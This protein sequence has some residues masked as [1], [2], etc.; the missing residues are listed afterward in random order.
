ML[1]IKELLREPES[2][3]RVLSELRAFSNSYVTDRSLLEHRPTISL[4][5]LIRQT[6]DLD[7]PVTEFKAVDG[8]AP[9]K[10]TFITEDEIDQ[11]LADGPSLQ[12]S[13]IR[14]YSYFI[15]GH[16]AKE[17]AALLRHEYGDSGHVSEGW[18][19]WSDG[20]GIKLTRSD[21][22]GDY[23]T[24]HLNWNQAQKRIRDLI[25]KDRYLTNKERE[26]LPEHDKNHLAQMLYHFFSHVPDCQHRPFSNGADAAEAAKQIIPLLETSETASK[27][28]DT[29]LSDFTTVSPDTEGYT[30]MMFAMRDMGAFVRG[31]SPLFSPL[32]E[33][34]LQAEREVKERNRK[35]GQT[36]QK[37][38]VTDAPGEASGELAAV[39][40]ALASKR[41]PEAEAQGDGQFSL[42][43]SGQAAEAETQEQR[44][45]TDA[46][47]DHFLIEDLGDPE[48][49]QRLYALFTEGWSDAII[50]RKLEQEYSRS[51]RG[52]LEGGFCT[53]ADGTR[54]YAYFTKELRISPRPEGKMRH[55]S[56][57]EMAAHIRQ[58]IQ[59]G[60]YLS[61][62][63]LEQY[64]KDHAAPEPEAPKAEV[65]KKYSL[66]YGY[67]GNGLTVWNS[68][69]MEDGDYKTI[70]HI[71]PDRRVTFYADDLPEEIKQEI[72][73]TAATSDARISATQDAPVF[74]APPQVPE[75]EQETSRSPWWDE[76]TAIKES[77]PNHL[78]LYQVGDFFELF[79]EDAKNAAA[80]LELTLTTRPIGSVGRVE[81]CGLPA[82]ALEQ[83]VEKLRGQYDVAISTVDEKTGAYQTR[84]MAALM[85]GAEPEKQAVEQSESP[86]PAGEAAAV[87]QN[88]NYEITVTSAEALILARPMSQAGI[89]PER[90]VQ[91]NGD[92]TFSVAE[93]EKDT[94][95]RLITK[96]RNDISKAAAAVSRPKKARRTR[97]ELNYSTFA[98]LFPE[99]ISGEYRSMRLQAGPSYMPLHV[100]W[101]ADDVV[102]L[103][104][105]FR[106]NGDTM[107]DPEMTFRV[108]QE[109][110]TMEALTFQQDGGV[111]IYQQVYPEPGKW[112]PKLRND[113]NNFA[114]KWMKN[115][116]AQ[117]F[118]R[119]RAV[120]VK[121]GEDVEVFFS[122]EGTPIAAYDILMREAD[123]ITAQLLND[124]RYANARMNSDEQNSRDECYI[125]INRIAV[126]MLKTNPQFYQA[127]FDTLVA[128]HQFREYLFETTYQQNLAAEQPPVSAVTL[129]REALA[130]LVGAVKGSSFYDY[131]RD[132]ETDYDSARNELDAEI[133]A[134]MEEIKE[135]NP[136]L[137]E[138]CHTLPKFREWLI[139][140]ILEQTYQ[141]VITDPRDAVQRYAGTPDAPAWI[142]EAPAQPE[143]NARETAPQE[144]MSEARDPLAPAYREGDTVYIEN[145][146]FIISKIDSFEI[147]LQYPNTVPPLLTSEEITHFE[148]LL[149]QDPRNLAISD[150][151]SADTSRITREILTAYLLTPNELEMVSHWFRSGEGNIQI[152][153][154]I[155]EML[156]GRSGSVSAPWNSVANYS[157]DDKGFRVTH[158]QNVGFRTWEEVAAIYRS[159]WQLEFDGFSHEPPTVDTLETEQAEAGTEIPQALEAAPEPTGA[160]APENAKIVWHTPAGKE[161][162]AGDTVEYFVDGTPH[163]ITIDSIGEDYI[164]YTFPD[165]AQA[166]VEMFRD[167]FE[168]LLDDGTHS[169]VQKA[170]EHPQQAP[171]MEQSEAERGD[172]TVPVEPD[173][174]PNA[175][176]Y[177]ELKAQHPDKLIGVQVGEFMM[178][179]GKDA[180]EAASALGTKA[181]ILDIPGLGQTPTT[182]KRG[183]WQATLKKLLEHGKSVV[184]ARPDL[185]RGPDA[186]YE[187]I[188]ERDISEYIPL[189]KELTIDGRRMKVD[190]IDYANGKVS[191]LDMEM[192]E[193]YRYP[194]F[195]EEPVAYVREYVEEA[196][197]RE[198]E[199]TARIENV[200][201]GQSADEPESQDHAET[202]TLEEAK[203]LIEDF[204]DAEYGRGCADFSDLEHIGIAYTTTE[205]E[206][207]EIQ[208]EVNLLDFSVTQTLDGQLIEQRRYKT[209]REMIDNELSDLDF[210]D[211]IHMSGEPEQ[212]LATVLKAAHKPGPAP[213]PE[214]VEID[215]GRIAEPP[216]PKTPMTSQVVGRV[217]AGAF[218]V[219]FEELHVGPELHNFHITDEGLG[220]G[221]QKTKYQNNVAAIRTLKQIE[222]EGRLAARSEQEILSHYV[223]WGSLAPAFD[224][225]NKAWAKEFAEL[226]SL[227]TPEEY[228]A[229]R[230]TTLS[231]HYTSPRVIKAIYDAVGR[232]GFQP[233]NILEPSC[234]IGNF[235]GLLP[236]ALSG[237]NLY[238]VELDSLTGRIARQLYQKAHIT[239]DG[240]EN[241]DHPDDFFDLAVG[242]VPF[243]SYKVHDRRYDRHNLQIHDYFL[244]KTLDKLRPG[245]I[246]AV[247]TSKGTMDKKNSKVRE[248]L[249]QKADLLGAIRLPNNAFKANAGT[250]VT[251]DILFFQKRATVPEKLPEWVESGLTADGV[252]LNQYY[253]QHPEMVL[254]TMVRGMSMYGNDTE[255]ACY[256]IEGA[257]L[258]EQLAG[259]ISH[260]APPDQELL[261]MDAPEQE[262]GKAVESIPADPNVRNFSYTV[263]KGKIYFRENSRMAPV[264]LGKKPTERVKGM[265]G[266]RDSARKL[267]DLQLKGADDTE[268]KAEQANLNRLYD[269]Y[270]KKYGILNNPGNRLAFNQDSSYPLLCSL[271]VLDDEGNFKQKADMFTKRTIQHHEAVT[272]VD[273][274]AEALA[275]S[276]GERACVDLGFM[277]SLMGDR[278]PAGSG[279]KIPQIVEDLK[280]IIFKDP[281]TGPFD[282][283]GDAVSWYKGWQTADEYLSGDVRAKLAKARA[284]AEEYPE[285]AVNAEA[286]EQVQP[287]DLTAAEISVRIGAPW[288]KPEYYR[289]F[290]FELLQVPEYLHEK[291]DVFYN[292]VTGEWNVKGKSV[293]KRD[294]ARIHATYGTKRRSAY[295]IFENLLN[296][297]DSRVYDE[298]AEGKR[299]L[300]PKHT[301]IAQQKAE[302]IDQA[303]RDWIFKDPERRADLCAT[304]N[305]IFNSKRPREYNGDHITFAGMNPE[306]KLEPHQRNAVARMLYGGNSLLAHCVGAG[307]TFEMTAA[308]M[309]S[310]RLGL[311][312]KSLFVVPNHLTEQWGSDF[313]TLY[314]GAKVLV[315]TKKDFKP[316][317]RKKFC[318]RIATG[319]YDAVIIGHSQFE[320]IPLSPERQARVIE[321]QIS[322]IMDAIREAKEQNEENWSIKQMEGTRKD[323][324]AKLKKLTDKKKDD[325]VTFEEL[326]ID[327]LFVD[328]AHYYKNLFLHTKM[329]NVAGIA[330]TEAQKSSDM[331][332][333]CRYLDELTGGRGVTFATGTPVSN[334]MVE[335]Y[336]MMRYLQFD[337]LEEAGLSHFDDWAAMFGEKVSAVELKPEG[338]GFRSKTRFARFYNLPELMNLWKEAA[339]IQTAEML[340]LPVPE[341]EYITVTTEP[342]AAQKEMVQSLAERAEAVRKGDVKPNVD[343]MLKITS[344]GRKLALDQRIMNPLLGDDPNSKVNAC[345]KNVF[346][347]WQE[348]TPTR[349]A[350]L[351]FCDLSTPK[352]RSESKK[353]RKSKI[354]EIID[355]VMGQNPDEVEEDAEG[356][357]LEMG[358]YDDIRAKLIAKGVPVEEIAFIHDAHT[359]AQKAELF[360]KVRSGQVRVLLGSTQKM[361][362]GTNVQKRLVASH[363]LDCPWRPADLEQRAGRIVRRGNDNKKVRIFRYVTKGT[364]DAYNWGLVENKQK[365][366][367]QIMTGKSPARSIEDVDATALSYAEVKM[368]AT[369]DPRIKEK[370]ELDIEVAKL[371]MLKANHM[372]QKYEMEDMVIKHYPQKMAEAKMFIRALT[373]DMQIRD[374]HPVKDDAFSMT[375][376][377]KTYT[378]R[379]A[380][381][382]AIL[383]A[384]KSMTEPDKPLDL[385]QFRGFPMQVQ[386]K[387]EKFVVTM[388]QNLT[389]TAELA[390]EILG[391]VTRI[392][393]ALEKITES[394][395]KQQRGLVT[396]EGNLENAREEA[397]RPFPQE[398]EL[399]AKSARL[400]E[401]NAELDNAESG[402]DKEQGDGKEPPQ[403]PSAPPLP[404]GD[405]P[406]I[407][408]ALRSYTP[409]APVAAGTEK[410]HYR[411][412]VL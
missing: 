190:S 387:G 173:F 341:A 297:R 28:F 281:A 46:D 144:E 243:G 278:S 142:Q 135:Q 60:R 362:A 377:G 90:T 405:K 313:L 291:I 114:A 376:C 284:A 50:V 1:R 131:L 99:I 18:Q 52:N 7:K 97:P 332:G 224:E 335:L 183:A 256:P 10:A 216:A 384:C 312:Q 363:D 251:S 239:V 198:F 19:T 39:A 317:N 98:K 324:E 146:P 345:V 159:L 307:K 179:Y 203:R 151:L 85:T 155:K 412:D 41:K 141:D 92:V 15:Q 6:A 103:G 158:Q 16:D 319:D 32:P 302:A 323:L 25:E 136:A 342:S 86:A 309:E 31:D 285:F 168:K 267:I 233:G 8:F 193:K 199:Q 229:A 29:M 253:L 257:D 214:Q 178:F 373:E 340:K 268:I 108:D 116:T 217:N 344:D 57:E 156:S 45:I 36:A 294:N 67:L 329:R 305:R 95:E 406:S 59:E 212:L 232:M 386:L 17:C 287:K 91:E 353:P 240:F 357:K 66:G 11:F 169:I 147:Q 361:G 352:G 40:R 411:G 279:D 396:L 127:Y 263:S 125:A 283:D 120:A 269:A 71:A 83:N 325:T 241:T 75:Q 225:H 369:G 301:A 211:L 408:A 163:Q 149:R 322:E 154:R 304:Y 84:T 148:Y 121:D 227:L 200:M 238:G 153:G 113:L 300:N 140:D 186:P 354:R 69:E 3:R 289:Q 123:A 112:I 128:V 367:G 111:P 210:E 14:I 70:A 374:M 275:V 308:A 378:E 220:T 349:G 298:G 402:K 292:K 21:E 166:P 371:K 55:V 259:A 33:S 274:A 400:S 124:E 299:V 356:V 404:G 221:G 242:N 187:I 164:Y 399:A 176:K 110:G 382:E 165:L 22:N 236:E 321:D 218:D 197:W 133:T 276:I 245:G 150:F 88:P 102:A 260:I 270:T 37:A 43:S 93:A 228:A 27:L 195:R 185:Q 35:K 101:I 266:I 47:L 351:V 202:D 295:V 196:E 314:P 315:A 162:R 87:V 137:H 223:G 366:I 355:K 51:R 143:R 180:E 358:V 48:R 246:M 104:H 61:P 252:P 167:R 280:G 391:N 306:Y 328:E 360:A 273:T 290:L 115:I 74:S 359:E 12:D 172:D 346:E 53:L 330:Q 194:V 192:A 170:S 68:M 105:T 72:Q 139:E 336:T 13:K 63:E 350:Q 201:E 390:D 160:G 26:S 272:S 23:D 392:N 277:A 213:E 381:G 403:E 303:F 206:R 20:K 288:V 24:V 80:V 333:K 235:F 109:K 207:H 337:M 334:S 343:N 134:M 316:K 370:M 188:K 126:S 375:I 383:A 132:R 76:Y 209:L 205:D 30:G 364:F 73:H 161:Y 81:M 65:E 56:F 106:Q 250:E 255:T 388:K 62:E 389:Y 318:A 231:A 409:P 247:I 4:P 230:A 264:E 368:L 204:C 94:L 262:D 226:Q 100:Q 254:G 82:H 58:L 258:A 38:A 327:R 372:A 331:F 49:R 237:A 379:K 129:Y 265:I 338:T 234:G 347:I 181:P 175:E 96:I 174:T 89:T 394:L 77:H 208:V 79:G 145:K 177:W 261:E 107:N 171:A 119:E 138:A 365:F 385:G 117:K 64:Q 2:R 54:G 326:G 191:L 152:A 398:E 397:A 5:A 122:P 42:F 339:D 189:G 401:L 44:E 296:Q 182:G 286:L 118:I 222:A 293:D 9:A 311:C 271:E 184:L 157:T 248:A 34:A 310:K 249:A 282:I 380:A 410:S 393:N 407:R 78:V 130:V 395:E 219:V 348:S 215:G 244:M 320:M